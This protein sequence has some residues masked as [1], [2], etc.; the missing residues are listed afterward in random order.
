MLAVA[1]RLPFIT[2]LHGTDITLVGR[3]RSY[4]P[5]TKF[6]IDQSD[7]VTAISEYLRA[8][9]VE[10]FGTSN[11]IRVIRNFVNCDIYKPAPEAR[12]NNPFSPPDEKVL[13]HI[14]NFRPVKRTQDCV[15]ILEAVRRDAAAHLLMVG[16]GPER[17]AAESLARELGLENHV[18]F[19]GKQNHIE[20]LLPLADVLLLPSQLESFGLAALEGMACGVPPV[21]TCVGGV[22]ELITDGV[23]GY[24]E[25][26]GDVAGQA[27]R[28]AALLADEA[29]YARMAKAARATAMTRFCSSHVIPLYERY[30]QEVCNVS[31]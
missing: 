26:P 8:K 29:L 15:R 5:I 7:G 30:Y 23:D 12:R 4:F 24:L 18:T 27:A 22:S 3:E 25:T 10:V 1:R 16:D 13:V 21:A 2:T 20:R 9:T 17:G 11:E 28:V 31:S 14:S 19:L 6:S